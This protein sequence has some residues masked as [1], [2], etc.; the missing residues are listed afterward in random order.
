[1]SGRSRER[2]RKSGREENFRGSGLRGAPLRFHRRGLATR[3]CELLLPASAVLARQCADELRTHSQ[4]DARRRN[5]RMVDRDERMGPVAAGDRSAAPHGAGGHSCAAAAPR[6]R[7]DA[8]R[9]GLQAVRAHQQRQPGR[10]SRSTGA[11]RSTAA[12]IARLSPTQRT[13]G[14]RTSARVGF[15]DDH[16]WRRRRVS[17]RASARTFGRHDSRNGHK[18]RDERRRRR[19]RA[20]AGRRVGPH[21][22]RLERPH[23]HDG[24]RWRRASALGGEFELISGSEQRLP[25]H[26]ARERRARRAGHRTAT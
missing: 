18:R 8:Q 17:K 12:A 1:M 4:A 16:D 5:R 10:D 13:T 11:N 7:R 3:R 14:A 6:A 22:H 26:T 21:R 20:G 15:G 24:G 19:E 23:S 25:G 2:P 9:S